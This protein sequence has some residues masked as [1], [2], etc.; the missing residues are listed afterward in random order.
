[1]NATL[2]PTADF[3]A[4][5]NEGDAERFAALFAEDVVVDDNGREFL[6]LEALREWAASDIF[7]VNVTMEPFR[8]F[9]KEGDLVVRAKVDGDFDRTGLP[10]P[11]FIDQRMT[12][13]NGKIAK[14]M[15]RLADD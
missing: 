13:R 12:V 15:C 3:V 8:T 5:V 10:D 9:E 1:M 2:N 4:A 11:L 7:A 6:G 14:L